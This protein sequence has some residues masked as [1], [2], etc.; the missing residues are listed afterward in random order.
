MDGPWVGGRGN[1][2]E[3]GDPGGVL[4]RSA[5]P[6]GADGGRCGI[7]WPRAIV[8]RTHAAMCATDM[9]RQ[10]W[11]G[12]QRIMDVAEQVWRATRDCFF[13]FCRCRWMLTVSNTSF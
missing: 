9:I 4:Q 2:K 5:R 3:V 13:V 10:A 7:G 1:G 6:D 12:G 8:S 11:G